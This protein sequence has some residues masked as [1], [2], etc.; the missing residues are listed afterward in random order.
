[1]SK[2]GGLS[3]YH[4]EKRVTNEKIAHMAGYAFWAL[5]ALVLA[6]VLVWMLGIK[7]TMIGNS[8][9]P[10]L[11]NGQ[12]VLID[13]FFYNFIKPHRGDVIVYRPNG[14]ENAHLAI[15]RVIGVPGDT[16]LIKNGVLVLN[17]VEQP[18]LFS[19]RI[20]DGGLAETQQTL[21]EDEYF[22]MGDN[23]NNSEDSRSANLG[24]VH[25]DTI[26][27]RAWFHSAAEDSGLG[28]VGKAYFNE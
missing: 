14:N 26:F 21:P 19:D 3:F 9:E 25:R 20:E 23:C 8:M 27:G 6:Y 24:N 5:P 1:M 4:R 16:I 2:K 10:E 18:L 28:P 12:E 11:Y 15:K 13:R 17:G 22:V 7:T